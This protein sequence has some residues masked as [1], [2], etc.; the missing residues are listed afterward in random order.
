VTVTLNA[1]RPDP[2][3]QHLVGTAVPAELRDLDQRTGALLTR[4]AETRLPGGMRLTRRAAFDYHR[5]IERA[6]SGT[7]LSRRA[8]S[9]V[10]RRRARQVERLAAAHGIAFETDPARRNPTITDRS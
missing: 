7:G 4:L 3:Q 6:V 2:A 5:A 9:A 10:A 1:P 8:W